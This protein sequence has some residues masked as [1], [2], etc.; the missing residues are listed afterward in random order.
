M[1]KVT[2]KLVHYNWP[3]ELFFVLL[4][5]WI[6]NRRISNYESTSSRGVGKGFGMTEDFWKLYSRLFLYIAI[7]N[8][9]LSF[10]RVVNTPLEGS[11]SSNCVDTKNKSF[12]F[13]KEKFNPWNICLLCQK[14]AAE[15]GTDEKHQIKIDFW[16]RIVAFCINQCLTWF[17]YTDLSKNAI[18][19]IF[20]TN[21]PNLYTKNQPE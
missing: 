5:F 3:H 18:F 15:T 7:A 12:F 10:F 11:N 1:T 14:E 13:S 20:K 16:S 9:L 4:A 2:L 8:L 21:I 17:L 19:S 6:S